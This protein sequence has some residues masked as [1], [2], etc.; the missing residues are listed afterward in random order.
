MVE[1]M[2]QP[3]PMLPE[4]DLTDSDTERAREDPCQSTKHQSQCQLFF[5]SK[6]LKTA[7]LDN[8]QQFNNNSL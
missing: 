6:A 8:V 3:P 1:L 2:A 5:L 4:P 7:A